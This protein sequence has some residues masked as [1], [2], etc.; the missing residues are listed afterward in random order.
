[1]AAHKAEE[2]KSVYTYRAK[3]SVIKRAKKKVK[4]DKT[5]LS[6]K[7]EQLLDNYAADEYYRAMAEVE[8]IGYP[9]K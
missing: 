1:M 9:H 3:P 5:T 8:Q 2:A 7:I 6:E 4:K